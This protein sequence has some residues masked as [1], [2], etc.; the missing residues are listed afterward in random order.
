MEPAK[1]S[2]PAGA[3][4]VHELRN[5][6]PLRYA[7]HLMEE[8]V[9]RLDWGPRIGR[10]AA[11]RRHSF[12]DRY[13]RQ[14]DTEYEAL[15]PAEYRAETTGTVLDLRAEHERS[16]SWHNNHRFEFLIM[17]GLPPVL[18]R[19]QIQVYRERL[20][21][22]L[23]AERGDAV[24]GPF[25]ESAQNPQEERELALGMLGEIQRL[26]VVRSEFE[27]LRKRLL[28]ALVFTGAVFGSL[29]IA[30]VSFEELQWLPPVAHVVIAGLI[31]GYFSVL[32]RLGSLHW[33]LEYNANYQ[34]VDRFDG[35]MLASFM[36][37][38]FE[39]AVA[40]FV[41]Y[42]IF[43]GGLLDGTFFP[44]F[45]QIPLNKYELSQVFWVVP[46][47]SSGGA[48]LLAWCILAGF[49]ERMIPDA[50]SLLAKGVQGDARRQ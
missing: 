17:A 11:R 29:F 3:S 12:V 36:L 4:D 35:T 32:L 31:G 46:K 14:L 41:L 27:K 2:T 33:S 10:L 34:Q 8:P 5:S 49:S 20:L 7:R 47:D 42:T 19:Q 16:P 9:A 24:L 23:G 26:R 39:G 48:K 18:L 38:M 21:V 30:L 44:S 25:A 40:A 37:A 50:L 28:F 43:L 15:C 6:D 22:L 45:E 1:S 13:F